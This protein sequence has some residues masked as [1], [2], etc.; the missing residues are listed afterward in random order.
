VEEIVRRRT[1]K[2][3][4]YVSKRNKISGSNNP[5]TF[6]V[7]N[8]H[9]KFDRLASGGFRELVK[10][11]EE[12]LAKEERERREEALKKKLEAA[13]LLV[14]TH[15]HEEGM[16]SQAA[17]DKALKAAQAHASTRKR[18]S[19]ERWKKRLA[20][21]TMLGVRE[22]WEKRRHEESG[23]TFYHRVDQTTLEAFSHDPPAPWLEAGEG[24]VG[25]T[26]STVSATFSGGDESSITPED[27]PMLSIKESGEVGSSTLATGA[28]SSED[29]AKEL[30]DQ[31]KKQVKQLEEILDNLATNDILISKLADKIGAQSFV[32]LMKRDTTVDPLE[33]QLE[34]DER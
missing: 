27:Q 32:P 29:M 18:S 9:G 8:R 19:L 7:Y 21:S 13:S 16:T 4:A 33:R 3:F 2:D 30:E 11:Y 17:K 15:H 25:P 1:P 22:V 14:G 28:V 6:T 5:R 10:Y 23:N 34:E 20:H 31:G 24:M 26:S 12:K